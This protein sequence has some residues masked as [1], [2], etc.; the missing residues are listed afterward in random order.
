MNKLI[1]T[2]ASLNLSGADTKITRL[3]ETTFKLR[4]WL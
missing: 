2:L 3:D 1:E 4:L